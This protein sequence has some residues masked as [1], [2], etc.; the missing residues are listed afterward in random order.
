MAPK[1]GMLPPGWDDLD[2]YV[3]D[4]GIC[5]ILAVFYAFILSSCS[6]G[7][8]AIGFH[9]YKLFPLPANPR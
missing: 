1:E 6:W 7:L 2:R 3:P 8:N 9:I 5:S 4:L